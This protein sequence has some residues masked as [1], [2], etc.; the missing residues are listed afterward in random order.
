VLHGFEVDFH[1]PD[2]NLAVELDGAAAHQARRK[3]EED[4]RRDREL[5][6]QGLRVLRVTWRQPEEGTRDVAA[7]LRR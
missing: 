6:K 4:R 5:A 2:Q 3:F 7:I 1:W